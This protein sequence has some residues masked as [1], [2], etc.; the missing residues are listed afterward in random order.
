MR[1]LLQRV[2]RASVE[3]GGQVVGACGHGFL[4]LLGVGPHDTRQVCERLWN[5]VLRLR[6]FG[7]QNGKT[8]LSLEDVG[9]SVLV[10]SQFTL[11]AD[12]RHG[13]RPSFTG[14]AAPDL[15]NELYEHFCELAEKDLG[16]ARV[17]RGIFGADMRV[18]LV[19]D[20]PFTMLLDTDELGLGERQ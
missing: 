17:G 4:V 5:K 2:E 3:V 14:A 20:G 11:Y 1:A 18:S 8:N 7:D 15:A 6:I 19:N 9:E 13:N 10:V 12:A 16:H